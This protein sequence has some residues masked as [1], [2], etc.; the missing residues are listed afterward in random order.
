LRPEARRT[1]FFLALDVVAMLL[2]LLRM[3]QSRSV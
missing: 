3:V 1:V 2:R